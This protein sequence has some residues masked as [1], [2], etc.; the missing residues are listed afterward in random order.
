[1]R[2]EGVIVPAGGHDFNRDAWC[3]LVSSRPEFRRHSPRQSR[4]P[5]SGETMIVHPPEDSAIVLLEDRPAGEVSW[6]MSDE[7]LVNV[8]VDPAAMPLVLEW[9][10]AL[11]AHFV[12]S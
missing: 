10:A 6:S 8:S 11:G 3:R 12:P 7:P 5:F 1:M 4:N 2:I 9:A